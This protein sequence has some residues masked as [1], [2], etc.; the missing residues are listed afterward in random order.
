MHDTR[1]SLRHPAA[2][3]GSYSG[4][5][6]GRHTSLQIHSYAPTR[7]AGTHSSHITASPITEEPLAGGCLPSDLNFLLP[8]LRIGMWEAVLRIIARSA[9]NST[10]TSFARL[11]V[12]GKIWPLETSRI[13]SIDHLFRKAPRPLS[14]ACSLTIFFHRAVCRLGALKSPADVERGS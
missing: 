1:A 2:A 11:A 10:S 13:A 7:R 12:Y 14:P 4:R 9:L 3:A 6:L 5:M 8:F